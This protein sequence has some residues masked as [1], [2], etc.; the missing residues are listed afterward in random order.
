MIFGL[1]KTLLSAAVVAVIVSGISGCV[2]CDREYQ[3]CLNRID[4][5]VAQFTAEETCKYPSMNR[6]AEKEF[7]DCEAELAA[8]DE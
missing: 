2:D 6:G 1:R 3:A 8:C 5:N 4:G 7:C